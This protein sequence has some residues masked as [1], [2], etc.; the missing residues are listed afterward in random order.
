MRKSEGSPAAR[1]YDS[2]LITISKVIESIK[3]SSRKRINEGRLYTKL[4][5]Y[6]G[7]AGLVICPETG[8]AEDLAVITRGA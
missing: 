8:R 4:D 1:P 2:F 6:P 5:N 3:V 7:K